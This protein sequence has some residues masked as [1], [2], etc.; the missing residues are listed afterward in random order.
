LP[1]WPFPAP[2]GSGGT[3]PPPGGQPAPAGGGAGA[4]TPIDPN[5]ASAATFPLNAL[6]G[7]EAAGMAKEGPTVAGQFSEGQILEQ[8][9]Q[10]LP[11]K[12]YTV[13]A[14]G[15]GIQE[16]DIQIFAVTPV[17]NLNGALAQDSG[18]GASASLGGRGNCFKWQWP[19]GINAKYVLRAT[20]G[21]GVAAG[22]L[23]V[24]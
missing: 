19:V 16:M 24:K 13:L 6:A 7:S 5:L 8:Q 11:G 1:G 18:S 15:A 22:Q 23:Y 3:T 12:C 9:F 14:V 20:R 2:S 17:P 4:A 21:Q 10:M